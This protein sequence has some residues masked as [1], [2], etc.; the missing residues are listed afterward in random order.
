MKY[1]IYVASL[2]DYN[3][4][5]LHGTWIDLENKNHDEVMEEIQEMLA[6]S[7]TA[8][9]TGELAEEFAIH[10]YE[11]FDTISEYEDIETLIEY[12][13][14]V[15]EHG[16][17]WIAYVNIT[18]QK[19]VTKAGFEA[20]YQGSYESERDFVECLLDDTGELESIPEH[21]RYYFDYDSYA[22]DL[23]TSDFECE[24]VEGICYVFY[25]F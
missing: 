1:Q 9:K 25:R 21:L 18:G 10:D 15:E 14:M 17:A 16:D 20:C 24:Y 23:F 12:V 2:T 11:G 6:D 7:P 4:G 3:A 13:E 5:I 19:W 22:N 8:R